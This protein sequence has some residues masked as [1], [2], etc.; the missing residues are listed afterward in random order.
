MNKYRRKAI[1]QIIETLDQ[2]NNEIEII[3]EEEQEYMD[4]M[5]ENFQDSDNYYVAEEAV[6]NLGNAIE[7]IEEAI[8]YLDDAKR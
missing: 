4:N 1:E 7:S 6:D 3:Q 5:P 2:I 8:N